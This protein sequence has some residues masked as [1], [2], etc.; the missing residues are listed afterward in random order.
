MRRSLRRR[1]G[2]TGRSR[3]VAAVADLD[4]VTGQT[5]AAPWS[6][7]PQGLEWLAAVP[8]FRHAYGELCRYLDQA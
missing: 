6:R 1:F 2:S 4:R 8:D 5:S 7:L 3:W